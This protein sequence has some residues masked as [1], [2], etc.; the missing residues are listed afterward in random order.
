M[1]LFGSLLLFLCAATG[2]SSFSV[3]TKA[4]KVKV[5]ENEGA[6]LTCSYSADF[7]NSPRVEWKFQDKGKVKYVIYDGKP[8]SDYTSRVSMYTGSNLR[9][10]KVTRQDNGIYIC[11]VSSSI[12]VAQQ[13]LVELTVLVPPSPPK[14]GIPQTVT[15]NKPATLTCYD[16]DSSPPPTHKWFKDNVPMPEDP[17]KISAFK[18]ATYKLDIKNGNLVFPS[19][20]KMDSAMYYCEVSNEAGPPQRCQGVRMEVRDLN[21]GGI[22][23]GV[24]ILLLLVA[25]V[26]VGVWY[27][28]KK[29]YLPKKS[30]SKQPSAVY[31]PQSMY[32]DGEEDDGDFKQ[33]SSFV[34]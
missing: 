18:N 12:G 13:V 8:T 29:G 26:I 4:D 6:D 17:S 9:F 10:S 5:K 28:N 2:V 20:T 27:A 16:P 7:G 31:Q 15:T 25:A 21:T 14:C 30:Q 3:T 33:K 11:E 22:V 23:A 1:R 34:V 19:V 32:G 24:I